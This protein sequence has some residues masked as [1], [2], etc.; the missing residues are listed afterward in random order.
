M[1][2]A[3]HVRPR[4]GGRVL[5]DDRGGRSPMQHPSEE[6]RVRGAG[7]GRRLRKRA[8]ELLRRVRERRVCAVDAHDDDVLRLERR[9]KQWIETRP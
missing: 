6:R 2:C 5:P 1:R 3:L 7:R 9:V 4:A 8:G